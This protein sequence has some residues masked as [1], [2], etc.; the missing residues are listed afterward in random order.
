MYTAAARMSA[1][2]AECL[3]KINSGCQICLFIYLFSTQNLFGPATLY[4]CV[5]GLNPL[6]LY[7]IS[8]LF[9]M[10]V[11]V[12]CKTIDDFSSLAACLATSGTMKASQQ[13]QCFLVMVTFICL[14]SASKVGNDF[15]NI[16]VLSSYD[17]QTQTITISCIWEWGF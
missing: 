2:K 8:E 17:M 1:L 15:S 7:S 11:P 9:S 16:G 3:L 4:F 5:P 14:C 6:F 10:H 13:R 12:L